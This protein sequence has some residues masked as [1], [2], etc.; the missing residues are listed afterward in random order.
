VSGSGGWFCVQVSFSAMA[1]DSL[2][3]LQSAWRKKDG[4]EHS[5]YFVTSYVVK[6]VA[7][8]TCSSVSG[9]LESTPCP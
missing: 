5:R 4:F 2:L 6:N 8:A 7:V 9:S 1:P 3:M